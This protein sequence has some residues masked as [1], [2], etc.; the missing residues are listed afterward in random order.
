[1]AEIRTVAAPKLNSH[2]GRFAIKLPAFSDVGNAHEAAGGCALAERLDMT[3]SGPNQATDQ[4]SAV[5]EK[6][7]PLSVSACLI[8]GR[9]RLLNR[10]SVTK[11]I[12]VA[13][14][15]YHELLPID[16]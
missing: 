1:M 16:A 7:S 14:D 3:G 4:R 6:P 11:R 15:Q 9:W 8:A 13:P 10:T 2:S 12:A 5:A